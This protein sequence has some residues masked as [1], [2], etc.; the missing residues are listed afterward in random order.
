MESESSKILSF[1]KDPILSWIEVYCQECFGHLP[2]GTRAVYVSILRQFLRWVA[3]RTEKGEAF[4]PDMLSTRAIEHYLVCLANHGYSFA[5]CKRVKSVIT[6]FCQWL[7]DERNML[8]KNPARGVKL[9][10]PPA[11]DLSAPCALS[12]QV[13]VIFHTLIKQD[14]LRG[15]ALFALGYWAGCRVVDLTHLLMEHTHVGGRSGWLHLGEP[16]SKV[17]DIDLVNEARRPLHAYLQKRAR[18]ESSPYVFTSQRSAR[19]S[20]AGFHHW[21]RSLKAQATSLEQ[22]VIADISFHDL[23]DD[24]A[25]RAISAGWTLE[26]IA[27]YLGHITGSGTPAIQTTLRY[28]QI[29]R[30]QVKEKLKALKG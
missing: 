20:E 18:D 25:S 30:A 1:L 17:R 10:Q 27:Y 14:D 4:Q 13:R 11:S 3:E 22:A 26:E 16:S 7:V 12:P 9:A 28:T 24:F 8:A 29:T 5:H 23:R 21:F 19:L 2:S 6:H 15:Q